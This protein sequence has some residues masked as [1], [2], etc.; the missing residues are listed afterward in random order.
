MRLPPI[1]ASS[2]AGML[3]PPDVDPGRPLLAQLIERCPH[4]LTAAHAQACMGEWLDRDV[5]PAADPIPGCWAL[6]AAY[7]IAGALAIRHPSAQETL[8]ALPA[9]DR[10]LIR[11]IVESEPRGR[12][13]RIGPALAAEGAALMVAAG[14]MA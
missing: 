6:V 1:E 8:D 13:E 14:G 2:A 5:D 12:L 11:E 3:T 10:R 4:P 9:I 7:G